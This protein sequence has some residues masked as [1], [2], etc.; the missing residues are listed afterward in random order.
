MR[1][2]PSDCC[3]D[4]RDLRTPGQEVIDRRP[5]RSHRPLST[6]DCVLANK[7]TLFYLF[8]SIGRQKLGS[9]N[10]TSS[11]RSCCG[12]VGAS[13]KRE[14]AAEARKPAEPVRENAQGP[15]HL[16]GPAVTSVFGPH[17]RLDCESKPEEARKSGTLILP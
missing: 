14:H 15:E 12:Q 4:L 8:Y 5:A 17:R 10:S 13:A 3:S 6:Y 7:F 9:Q 16:V 11:S 2:L 1:E